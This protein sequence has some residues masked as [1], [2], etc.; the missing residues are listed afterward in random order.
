MA[1]AIVYLL[2]ATSLQS[3]LRGI[4]LPRAKEIINNHFVDDSLFTTFVDKNFVSTTKDC[5]A[6]FCKASWKIVSDHKTNYWLVGIEDY[7]M[8]FPTSWRFFQ[9]GVIVQYLWI[10]FRVDISLVAM[11]DWC[12]E[13]LNCNIIF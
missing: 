4:Y 5:L 13:I 8:W 7:P 11:W 3:W 12:L 9:Q 10:P 1:N 2:E 6:M